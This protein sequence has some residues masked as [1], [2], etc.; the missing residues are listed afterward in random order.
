MFPLIAKWL[1][2]DTDLDN[3]AIWIG[4]GVWLCVLSLVC[5][6]NHAV[7]QCACCGAIFKTNKAI[8]PDVRKP[9]HRHDREEKQDGAEK[10]DGNAD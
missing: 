1:L 9:L 6:A 4:V 3:V 2:K 5:L 8:C 7:W 10:T